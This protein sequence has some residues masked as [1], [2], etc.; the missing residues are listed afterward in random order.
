[1]WLFKSLVTGSNDVLARQIDTWAKDRKV[2]VELDW[3]TLGDREPKF[4]AASFASPST[5]SRSTRSSRPA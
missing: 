4:V 1:V 3:A 2:D 5:R